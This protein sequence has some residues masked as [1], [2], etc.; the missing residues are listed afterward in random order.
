[1]LSPMQ[2]PVLHGAEEGTDAVSKVDD[3]I[4]TTIALQFSVSSVH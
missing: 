2:S 3:C 4:F 1:M